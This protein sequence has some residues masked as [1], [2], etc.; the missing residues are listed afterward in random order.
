MNIQ[1]LK[2]ICVIAESDF[3][4]SKAAR[5]VHLSQSALSKQVRLLEEELKTEFFVR[6]RGRL[7]A[8]TPIGSRVLAAAK[9][10][11]GSVEEIR[12]LCE[13]DDD[14]EPEKFS[15]GASRSLAATLL[16]DVV[17]KFVKKHVSIEISVIQETL[18]CLT[19]ML[20]QGELSLILTIENSIETN[21][22]IASLPIDE[23]PRIIIMPEGHPL[24]QQEKIELGDLA[25]YPLVLY[26]ESFSL[27][28]EIM[29]S[30]VAKRL[31]PKVSLNARSA[32]VIIAHVRRGIGVGVIARSAYDPARHSGISISDASHLF[33]NAARRI[34]FNKHRFLRSF[35]LDFI[36]LCAPYW[37]RQRILRLQ[38]S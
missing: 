5:T 19:H 33:P 8:L 7:T 25:K 12:S 1:Q 6:N 2:A 15:V 11:L 13:N 28:H 24:E 10:I 4:M 30:F 23:V 38:A 35:E 29:R 34:L 36:E 16:P 32:E 18:S 31:M 9:G 22:H 37:T 21:V 26:D 20:L 17:E 27:R 3:N 14:Q